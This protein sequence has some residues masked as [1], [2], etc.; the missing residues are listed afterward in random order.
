[1]QTS[2]ST[3][4]S[5]LAVGTSIV[6]DPTHVN[7]HPVSAA[8]VIPVAAVVLVVAAAPV[9]QIALSLRQ[10]VTNDDPHTWKN[11]FSNIKAKCLVPRADEN[12][13]A[14]RGIRHEV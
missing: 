14:V 4:T 5:C 9:P 11:C 10:C 3:L 7:F 2:S 1:M 8:V 13:A 6:L 12:G